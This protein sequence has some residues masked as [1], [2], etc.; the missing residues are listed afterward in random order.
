M[1]VENSPDKGVGEAYAPSRSCCER[2][3]LVAAATRDTAIAGFLCKKNPV[4]A[5]QPRIL[6][7]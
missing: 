5:E 1:M 3:V 6:E 2:F 4:L 7:N